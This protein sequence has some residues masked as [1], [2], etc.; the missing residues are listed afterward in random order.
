MPVA[1]RY[2]DLCQSC[3]GKTTQVTCIESGTTQL[4]IPDVYVA[5]KYGTRWIETKQI[6]MNWFPGHSNPI[7]FRKGQ[8][9]WSFN[10]EYVTGVPTLCIVFFYNIVGFIDMTAKKQYILQ[11]TVP[12]SCYHGYAKH[13]KDIELQDIFLK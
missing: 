3:T 8:L 13:I 2:A 11:T 4:G 10:H 7:P 5:C 1:I 9:S 6:R 12:Y